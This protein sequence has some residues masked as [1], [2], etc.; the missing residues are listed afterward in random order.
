MIMIER[1]I[2]LKLLLFYT[3]FS[4]SV[5]VI[6]EDQQGLET[7]P[8]VDLVRYQGRWFEIAR[9]PNR[10][11]D[12]CLGNVTANY[13]Q[14]DDGNIEVINRCLD[15]QGKM[16]EAKGIARIIDR[17]TNAKLEVSF[18]SLLGWNLF[19]GD[20]WVVGLGDSYEYAIIGEPSRKY[21]WILSRSDHLSMENWVV[22]QQ[23]LIQSGYDPND[24]VQ[25]KHKVSADL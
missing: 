19:W 17:S 6:A 16:D 10:F 4:F 8:E 20:Y 22:I 18:V 24:F 15:E 14:L 25:T 11:Q 2:N 7:V 1:I 5:V 23:I 13:K 21:G 9:L 12:Q 3:L